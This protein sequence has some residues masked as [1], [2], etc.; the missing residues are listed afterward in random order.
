MNSFLTS[1]A[2]TV[3]L[4]REGHMSIIIPS[5]TISLSLASETAITFMFLSSLMIEYLIISAVES[6]A[7]I[8]E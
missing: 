2:S 5:A 8:T 7:V 4:S 3:S 1:R 6:M